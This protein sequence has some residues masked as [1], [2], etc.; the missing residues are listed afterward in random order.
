MIPNVSCPH[1]KCA[2]EMLAY[3]KSK[4]PC[5]AAFMFMDSKKEI[6]TVTFADFYHG[7]LA[8]QQ[9]LSAKHYLGKR[10]AIICSN[11]VEWIALFF[12]IFSSC[13][14][15]VPIGN[16]YGEN[17][18]RN[19]IKCGKIEVIFS[20]KKGAEWLFDE[21]PGIDCDVVE[22]SK[23]HELL[24]NTKNICPGT[25][26]FQ[27]RPADEPAV[28]LFTSGTTGAPKAVLLSEQN[29]LD[30]LWCSL[31]ESHVFEANGKNRT[32]SILPYHHVYALVCDI[33][34]NI[35]CCST[36]CL[37]SSLLDIFS[38]FRSYKPTHVFLVPAL[39][40]L[41]KSQVEYL[42]AKQKA[43]EVLREKLHKAENMLYSQ[44]RKLFSDVH[45][46]FG[47][48][49]LQI[50]CGGAPIDANTRN[51]FE[52][53]GIGFSVGY[54]IT[55]CASLISISGKLE[56]NEASTSVGNV[57][58][59]DKCRIVEPDEDGIGEIAVSGPNIMLGYFENEQATEEAIIEGWYFTGDYGRID[60][61]NHLI[62]CGRAANKIILS[63][64]E[65][66]YPEEI[67]TTLLGIDNI[68]ECVIRA[69]KNTTG[70]SIG[71]GAE[72]VLKNEALQ[73]ET[74]QTLNQAM[75]EWPSYRR[76]SSILFVNEIDKQ[77][78]GIP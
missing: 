46:L 19:L 59:I 48:Q 17:E 30:N 47:G 11:S 69:I 72:I 64:G 75:K 77:T 3:S 50:G 39:A 28:M 51:F 56:R 26:E 35:A 60:D 6:H 37:S 65:N 1:F 66:I 21:N 10:I 22:M 24:F 54:G 9:Y 73:D 7:V 71:I 43:S 76:L 27:K 62:L 52:L 58:S 41:L 23:I 57:L 61:N 74:V 2:S 63:N 33:L 34:A 40:R 12:A 44:R 70:D 49:F 16:N 38:D 25:L 8:I 5:E 31:A 14:V 36:M 29:L 42:Y 45:E 13:G 78:K 4:A 53:L 15:V 20:E 18:K 68:S 55:E 32:Y 67:E